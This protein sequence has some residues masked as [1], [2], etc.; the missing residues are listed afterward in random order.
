MLVATGTLS[1]SGLQTQGNTTKHVSATAIGPN[2]FGGIL[3]RL[4]ESGVVESAPFVLGEDHLIM[5][6]STN[7]RK[8]REK[9]PVR[10][11]TYERLPL[12][13]CK[14]PHGFRIT[15]D[16]IVHELYAPGAEDL[17]QWENQFRLLC[18]RK[19]YDIKYKELK[20]LKDKTNCSVCSPS[21]E[22]YV[23]RSSY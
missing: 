16:K 4:L 1:L 21:L 14:I 6:D 7:F 22:F 23:D 10:F 12:E 18:Y 19:D 17:L 5:L 9:I 2:S 20:V 8:E 13:T 11:A 15:K 3:S